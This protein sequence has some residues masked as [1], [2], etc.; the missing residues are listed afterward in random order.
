MARFPSKFL[1]H[2]IYGKYRAASHG[3]SH[4]FKSSIAQINTLLGKCAVPVN[5][6]YLKLNF[7]HN[8]LHINV[9]FSI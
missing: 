6:I 9:Y 1:S 8:F 3:R 5:D 4:W 2:S 7:D